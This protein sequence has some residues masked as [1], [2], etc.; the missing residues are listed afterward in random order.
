MTVTEIYDIPHLWTHWFNSEALTNIISLANIGNKYKVT[1][2]TSK[3]KAM[4]AHLDDRQVKFT[5][6]P[7]GLYDQESNLAT[8]ME[9]K[10]DNKNKV[11][12]IN[13]RV[14]L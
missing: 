12:K 4:I 8:D 7:G 6:L 13:N 10:I 1:M 3:E 5:K 2:D 11:N 14:W 9:I